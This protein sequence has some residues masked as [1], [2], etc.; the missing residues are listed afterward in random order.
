MKAVCKT[1]LSAL[2]VAL[3]TVSAWAEEILLIAPAP[4]TGDRMNMPLMI[5]LIAVA[6]VA[7]VVLVIIML[8]NNK[9]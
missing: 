4:K 6:V 7:I 5:G 1:L 3:L 8:R 9:K 2:L